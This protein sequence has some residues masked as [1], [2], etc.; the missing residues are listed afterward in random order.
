[1]RLTQAIADALSSVQEI[2][3]A[4]EAKLQE[5]LE[6]HQRFQRA[7][8]M[9]HPKRRRGVSAL[10]ASKERGRRQTG[11]VRLGRAYGP[12]SINAKADALQLARGGFWE[13]AIDMAREYP[14]L[15]KTIQ[16]M[17]GLSGPTLRDVLEQGT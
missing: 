16:R 2:A 10:T 11:T 9:A 4:G 3:A 7:V 13:E 1:V 15:V 14:E 6:G 17:E 8:F 12:G 5:L